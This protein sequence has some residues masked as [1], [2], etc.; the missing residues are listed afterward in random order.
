MKGKNK[1]LF[2]NDRL[3]ESPIQSKID[4]NLILMAHPIDGIVFFRV[5]NSGIIRKIKSIKIGN[6]IGVLGIK[7]IKK[8]ILL[9]SL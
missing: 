4:K 5:S 1:V 3:L 9:L 2:S 6:Q 8:G 7:E